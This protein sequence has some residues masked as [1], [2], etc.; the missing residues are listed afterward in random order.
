MLKNQSGIPESNEEN[1]FIFDM[2]DE[3]M[4]LPMENGQ[5]I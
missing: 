1:T 2:E 3:I 4:D 5:V